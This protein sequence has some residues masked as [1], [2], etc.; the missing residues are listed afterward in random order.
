MGRPRRR[1]S[2]RTRCPAVWA[3]GVGERW[4]GRSERA[5]CTE[6]LWLTISRPSWTN[7]SAYA[8]GEGNGRS[9]CHPPPAES[10]LRP[11]RRPPTG[12]ACPV[13]PAPPRRVT[14]P[15]AACP[16]PPPVG[17][18]VEPKPVVEHGRV[19]SP[20][21]DAPVDP[22]AA[23]D[24]D[25]DT[26]GAHGGV[27]V[28]DRV[29]QKRHRLGAAG[30]EVEPLDLAQR[31]GPPFAVHAPPKRYRAPPAVAAVVRNIG[32]RSVPTSAQLRCSGS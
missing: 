14:P 13:R 23:E 24:V 19:G 21:R 8:P 20:N 12:R 28:A 6:S 2:P 15:G 1:R 7:A 10:S 22:V 26:V 9:V 27:A 32:C 5:A 18:A 16:L 3:A 31:R 30:R 11:D 4:R 17:L 29:G 25:A